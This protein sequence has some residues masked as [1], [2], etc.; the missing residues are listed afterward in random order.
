MNMK[1]PINSKTLK[2]HF[3]NSW[4]KYLLVALLAFGLVNLLYTMTAYRSPAEKKVEF[5]V[6]GVMDQEKLTAYMEK[7]RS[8]EMDDMEV[9]TPLQLMNDNY[10]GPMQLMTYMAAGEGDLYLL[11]R[12]E[13]VTGA[14]QGSYLPLEKD[15]ELMA[16][17][18]QAGI[19][20]QNGWRKETETGE[21]HLF[22]IPQ[23]KLP[24]LTQY[25][26]ATDGYLCIPINGGNDEN[27]LK[28][29]RILCRDTMSHLGTVTN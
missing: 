3:T 11:P 23:N 16:L 7:V 6:Y 12:D 4:W 20:L 2:Q 19:N 9:M 26:S 29:L 18:D 27:A 17:F 21:S 28:F 25:A 22:G 24:G 14:A 5:F 10:Y 1:T 15:P 13:F 8:E